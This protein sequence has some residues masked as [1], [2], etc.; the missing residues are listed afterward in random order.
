MLTKQAD[1]QEL[2]SIQPPASK[3]LSTRMLLSLALFSNELTISNLLESS[4]TSIFLTNLKKLGVQFAENKE[5]VTVTKSLNFCQFQSSELDVKDCGAAWRFFIAICALQEKE[6]FIKGTERLMARPIWPLLDALASLGAKVSHDPK[7]G[8]KVK[9]PVSGKEVTVDASLSSQFVSA[10]LFIAPFIHKE[11]TINIKGKLPSKPYIQL[12]QNVLGIFG[13]RSAFEGQRLTVSLESN[14]RIVPKGEKQLEVDYSSLSYLL[15]AAH[16]LGK[17]LF[18]PNCYPSKDLQGDKAI[19]E[20]LSKMGA[21]Y[22]EDEKG[23]IFH[24]SSNI[25]PFEYDFYFCPDIALTA[26]SL[27]VYAKGISRLKNVS[28]LRFKESDRLEAIMGNLKRTGIH[29][30]IEGNDLIISGGSI[31]TASLKSYQDHRVVMASSL[32]CLG[33]NRVT[34]DNLDCCSK[35]YPDFFKHLKQIIKEDFICKSH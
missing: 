8:T 31:Q 19:I 17:S 34:I 29:A 28:N 5:G 26:A 7:K 35:S 21:S 4:D 22:T 13:I 3:S 23:L 2:V 9:G 32:L 11:F 18:I 16:V 30:S 1:K 6:I 10:L 27:A 24:G 14:N 12:T 33:N 25:L 20:L 15:G